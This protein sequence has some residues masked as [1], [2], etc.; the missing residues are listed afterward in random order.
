MRSYKLF[1]NGVWVPS[2][3]RKMFP[4]VNPA[5]ERV[6]GR[7]PSGTVADVKKAIAAA[8]RAVPHWNAMPAP[9]RGERLRAIARDLKR[10]K[11]GLATIITT[12][13]GKVLEEARG[14]V[15]EAIDITDYMAGEGRRLFGT[16]TT[17]ELSNKFCMTIR[18]PLGVVGLI[19][20]WNF[21]IA[22][23]AWKI[24]PALVCGNTVVFKPSSDT[25]LCAT[26]LVK[27]IAKHVP[28]GVINLVT[29]GGA[30][31]G[32]ELVNNPH[33]RALSVTGSWGKCGRVTQQCRMA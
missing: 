15:Q 11:E 21:P 20:P 3:S 26:E 12:E 27:I 25:P 30:T 24:M 17:S 10:E 2:T 19:T 7:F 13:M 18:R 29:G 32:R 33:V 31:V 1:I 22:I 16:T 23:P 6:I 28:R 8:N 9:E 14:D 5:T 4:S